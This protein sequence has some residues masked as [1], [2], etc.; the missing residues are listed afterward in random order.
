MFKFGIKS[1]T[2]QFWLLILTGIGMLV[3]FAAWADAR[4]AKET[5]FKELRFEVH[6]LYLHDLSPTERA[7]LEA[8]R[9]ASNSQ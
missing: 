8:Q 7:G 1:D 5:E 4:Y 3:S 2:I 6:A 9:D